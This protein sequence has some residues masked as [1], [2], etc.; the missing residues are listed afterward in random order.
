MKIKDF[1]AIGVVSCALVS[2]GGAQ[3]SSNRDQNNEHLTQAQLNQLARE[4]HTPEQYQALAAHYAN[5]QKEFL[6]QAANAKAEWERRSQNVMGVLA[7]YPRPVDSAKY[8]YDYFVEKANEAGLR[9]AKYSQQEIS[10]RQHS[11]HQ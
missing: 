2:A 8:L 6:Q 10:S 1:I 9:S 3:V 11:G 4:A 5:E 7:K